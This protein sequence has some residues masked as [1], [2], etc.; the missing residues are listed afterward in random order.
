MIYLIRLLLATAIAIG[1]THPVLSGPAPVAVVQST[2]WT[3]LHM[4]IAANDIDQVDRLLALG[5]DPEVANQVGYRPLHVAAILGRASAVKSL[6][7]HGA[8]I[9][10]VVRG[11]TP[12]MNAI[13]AGQKESAEILFEMGADITGSATNG[14]TP[15]HIAAQYGAVW[16]IHESLARGANIHALNMQNMTPLAAAALLHQPQSVKALMEAGAEGAGFEDERVW[17]WIRNFQATFPTLAEEWG[18]G[19]NPISREI[20][21]ALVMAQSLEFDGTI[22]FQGGQLT[23]HTGAMPYFCGVMLKSI[24]AFVKAFPD[25]LNAQELAA[26]RSY[27]SFYTQVPNPGPEALLQKIQQGTVAYLPTGF[28]GHAVVSTI[29]DDYLIINNKGQHSNRPGEIYKINKSKITVDKIR[30][31]MNGSRS[32]L[33]YL[34][35]LGAL[36]TTFGARSDEFSRLIEGLYPLHP[37]QTMGN[38]SWESTETGVF[39]TLAVQR[40]LKPFK[41]GQYPTQ[42]EIQRLQDTFIHWVRFTQ[43]GAVED[44]FQRIDR[45]EIPFNPE[46]ASLVHAK[47]SEITDWYGM[48]D[49]AAALKARLSM[50]ST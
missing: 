41:S 18:L 46:L 5:A 9:N 19:R 45:G 48:D 30:D 4:A 33:D 20:F 38:C 10:A 6:L 15:L 29:I 3:P 1:W 8:D 16:A 28:S 17:F 26:L 2:D 42:S 36:P 11:L 43:L 12:L 39:F 34:K 50:A 44:Y 35:W 40:F 13:A 49:R 27:L 24:Q 31:M 21:A 22:H 37:H 14:T 32:D 47:L 7:A 25:R 23:L